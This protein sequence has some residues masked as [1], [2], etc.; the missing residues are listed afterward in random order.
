MTEKKFVTY[1]EFGAAGDGVTNDFRAMKAAHDFANEKGFTVKAAAGKTYYISDTRIDGSVESVKI[2]TDVIWSG[3]EFIIDDSLYST[4]ENFG[5][6]DT[7]FS[8]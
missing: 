2:R 3:A 5:M 4:H 6:F 8:K 7:T 1:E